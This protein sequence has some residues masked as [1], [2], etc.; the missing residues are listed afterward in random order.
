MNKPVTWSYQPV[1]YLIQCSRAFLSP[2]LHYPRRFLSLS[3]CVGISNTHSSLDAYTT[4]ELDYKWFESDHHIDVKDEHL[5]ELTLT[6]TEAIKDV[7]S[8]A[9]GWS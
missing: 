4:D 9:D 6:N 5:A 8:Y 1:K 3:C 2:I 7:E